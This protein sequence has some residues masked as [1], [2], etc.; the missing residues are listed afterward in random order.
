MDELAKKLSIIS[1][2]VIGVI[3][4]IGVLQERSW[5]EMFTIGGMRHFH[6]HFVTFNTSLKHFKYSVTRRC[7]YTRRLTDSHN[8]HARAGSAQD[9]EAKGN[10]EEIAFSRGAWVSLCYLFRQ[11]RCVFLLLGLLSSDMVRYEAP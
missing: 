10:S 6:F 9:G 1:F 2:A 11:D 7:C 4:L 5:L 3:C 8:C